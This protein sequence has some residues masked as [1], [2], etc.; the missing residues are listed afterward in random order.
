MG[1]VKIL[2]DYARF[3]RA[4]TDCHNCELYKELGGENIGCLDRI[5]KYTEA[6]AEII[7]RWAKERPER[8]YL[9]DFLKKFPKAKLNAYG[10]PYGCRKRLYGEGIE[11]SADKID[12]DNC[13]NCWF[14]SVEV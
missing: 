12:V 5:L 10:L 8:T 14:E 1:E 9:E 3:C 6:A 13:T 11:C 4:N 7:E 2:R